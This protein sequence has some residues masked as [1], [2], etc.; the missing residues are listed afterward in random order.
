MI[1]PFM[2]LFTGRLFTILFSSLVF[3]IT[4]VKGLGQTTGQ[5]L[6]RQQERTIDFHFDPIEGADAYQAEIKKSS[7]PLNRDP[8][9]L[10]LSSPDF[11]IDLFPGSY[12]VRLRSVET[13]DSSPHPRF[14]K[15]GNWNSFI[16][17][18]RSILPIYPRENQILYPENVLSHPVVLL[19]EKQRQLSFYFLRLE[20]GAGKTLLE[21]KVKT[22]SHFVK[23]PIDQSYAWCVI[24]ILDKKKTPPRED[25]TYSRFKI[26]RFDSST[27][28]IHIVGKENA[29]FYQIEIKNNGSEA[30]SG[31]LDTDSPDDSQK[32]KYYFSKDPKF[33]TKLEMGE[34]WV[35]TKAVYKNSTQSKWSRQKYFQI[36]QPLAIAHLPEPTE[37]RLPDKN[38]RNLCRNLDSTQSPKSGSPELQCTSQE[39]N[40]SDLPKWARPRFFNFGLAAIVAKLNARDYQTNLKLDLNLLG[41][42]IQ[43]GG[44]SWLQNRK[45]GVLGEVTLYNFNIENENKT[46]LDTTFYFGIREI[47][48]SEKYFWFGISYR[49]V[50]ELKASINNNSEVIINSDQIKSIGPKLR[51]NYTDE[52]SSK[53]GYLAEAAVFWGIFD[54]GTP[55]ALKQ[56]SRITYHLG[57]MVIYQL[58]VQWKSFFGYQYWNERSVYGDLENTGKVTNSIFSHQELTLNLQYV[59]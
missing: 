51:L 48:R 41:E 34:F 35:R 40:P 33:R 5:Q 58:N 22:N 31:K 19:W 2:G 14:G 8:K 32:E 26:N 13:R 15:W 16:V 59:F 25:C 49:E 38:Q 45:F 20:N 56:A 4:P 43:L 39:K 24:P 54:Q 7:D 47:Y 36:L 44:G 57:F 11:S 27:T 18:Y 53:F 1:G 12:A 30:S 21:R 28:E 9:L 29:A 50:P 6:K 3:Y 37:Q 17:P 10:M 52:I 23:I 55:H 42:S 46:F